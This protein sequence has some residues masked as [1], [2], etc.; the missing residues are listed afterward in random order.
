MM[1]KRTRPITLPSGWFFKGGLFLMFS[2]AA[3]LS[4]ADK[5]VLFECNFERRDRLVVPS[6]SPDCQAVRK[7]VPDAHGGKMVMTVCTGKTRGLLQSG[8]LLADQSVAPRVRLT[9]FARGTGTLLPG[10]VAGIVSA[11]GRSSEKIFQAEEPVKLTSAWQQVSFNCDL[12]QIAPSHITL[13]L[14]FSP[15]SMAEIDDLR[16]ENAPDPGIEIKALTPSMILKQGDSFPVCRFEVTPQNTPLL[17]FVICPNRSFTSQ[18]CGG[19]NTV[20][21]GELA[22]PGLYRAAAAARGNSAETLISVLPPEEYER[23]DAAA[24]RIKFETPVRILFLGDSISDLRR[25]RNGVDKLGFW[26]NKYSDGKVEIRNAAVRGDFITRIEARLLGE[27]KQFQQEK[28]DRLF[29][30]P[31][32]MI[33]IAV[34]A[35]DNR[36]KKED[37]YRKPLVPFDEQTAAMTRVIRLLKSRSPGARII[38]VGPT[39]SNE[40]LQQK[41]VESA[42]KGNRSYVC[43]AVPELTLMGMKAQKA[44]AAAENVE[45]IDFYEEMRQAAD[46]SFFAPWDTIHP[47]EKGFNFI[48][49]KVL[50]YLAQNNKTEERSQK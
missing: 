11:D 48:T 49:L 43:F 47:D 29:E 41:R 6:Y 25:G 38:L 18:P 13:R 7:E 22:A 17:G 46:T 19:D 50:E 34:S 15:E 31:W 1:Q 2:A 45:Y 36:T 40:P 23:C 35:N 21:F 33:F 42:E 3:F 28:Y 12:A 27:K 9:L 30:Q 44:A 16:F 32:Q 5:N 4:A 14:Q 39:A 10:L 37:G 8:P 24:R 20:S 26:L